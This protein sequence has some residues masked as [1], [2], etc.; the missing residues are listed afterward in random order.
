VSINTGILTEKNKLAF[1]QTMEGLSGITTKIN[2]GQGTIGQLVG[3]PSI[4]KNLDELS[5]D[6]KNNPWKLLYRPKQ[7]K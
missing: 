3:N 5:A 6:L 7:T 1:T 2:Q 4:Y